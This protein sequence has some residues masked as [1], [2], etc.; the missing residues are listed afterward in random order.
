[1]HTIIM[2][3]NRKSP[4]SFFNVPSD[5]VEWGCTYLNDQ[6]CYLIMGNAVT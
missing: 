2:I 5:K 4:R 6:K 1:M 3:F